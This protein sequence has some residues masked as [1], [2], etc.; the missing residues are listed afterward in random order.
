MTKGQEHKIRVLVVDDSA[1]MSR[2]I[3][4]IL[5][6]DPGIEVVGRAK[7]GLEAL[8]MVKDLAP[9]VVT[10]DVEMPRMNGI[11]AL[12]HIMVKYSI[13]TVMISALTK[14]GA[15]TTFDALKYGA[16]DV[17]AKPSRREDENLD[18]QKSDIISKVKRAAAIRTGRSRYIRMG[19]GLHLEQKTAK[20]RP[21]QSTRFIGIGAGTGGYYAL[22]RIIPAL[23]SDFQDIMIAVILVASKY[24]EPFVA[25][26]D[27]HSSI[28]VLAARG[29]GV[30]E[31][32]T[33]YV[34][35]GEDRL[36]LE[37]NGDGKLKFGL[38][39]PSPSE[40]QTG[41]ID[42]MLE[43]LGAFA[44][45]KSVGIIMSGAGRDGA[46]GLALL[47]QAG[48]IGVIQDINN[49]VDPSMPLAA[50]EKG[51]VEKVLPDYRIAEF[52]M[53]P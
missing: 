37:N 11:T 51:T 17:I 39:E 50:L 32:G 25:Y 2:Q 31:K 24:I 13:P 29:A 44:G 53:R 7:D 6:A 15:R 19:R 49:C 35:S 33:C 36:V 40:D 34:C 21:D 8:G 5:N 18:A 23:P 45:R 42:V 27:S 52:I 20:G 9:D 22:L 12:K 28:P 16:I 41:A 46:N 30:P 48:G 14:E 47:R 10:M 26:L 4:N 3:T 38:L 43:S 1:L